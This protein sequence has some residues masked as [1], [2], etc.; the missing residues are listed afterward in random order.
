MENILSS[1]KC[2]FG[3]HHII[4]VP[5]SGVIGEFVELYMCRHCNRYYIYSKTLELGYWADSIE[6]L[7]EHVQRWIN[8][9][10]NQ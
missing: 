4:P 6:E 7:P 9:Q 3:Y 5:I 1:L 8:D 10:S 2:F